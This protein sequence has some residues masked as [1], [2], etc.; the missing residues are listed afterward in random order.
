MN[1]SETVI[2]DTANIPL[3]SMAADKDISRNDAMNRV[4][5]VTWVGMGVNILLTAVKMGAGLAGGSQALVADAVHS[6]SDCSTDIA[7]LVGVRYWSNPPDHTHPHGHW[8]I[9]TLITTF[10][11]VFLA[12]AAV[13][14]GWKG[15]TSFGKPITAQLGYIPLLAALLSV[16][17]KEILYRWTLAEGR[18][19]HS[20]AV[21]A[22][23]WH[24]R[25]DAISSIPVAIAIAVCMA[26]PA[27]GF[28]DP[29]GA[30]AVCIFLLKASWSILF[31]AL[32][33]LS[34]K[35][36]D[37]ESMV[38]IYRIAMKVNG[39]R[40]VHALRTRTMASRVVADLHLMV[41]PDLSVQEGHAIAGKVKATILDHEMG[42]VDLLIHLEPWDGRTQGD[43]IEG[44]PR[45][46]FS[47][48]TDN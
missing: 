34:D 43:G 33:E 42:V 39:V 9:E 17:C 48:Q 45:E 5:H 12:I 23:A 16:V 37:T 22:N 35:A 32:S 8:R 21:I 15:L 44:D 36:I 29:L 2:T 46:T 30:L 13:A 41:D 38:E 6:L 4:L 28:L 27:F 31:P 7:V 18:K 25:S 19:V 24:H 40:H 11:G 26:N 14:I 20:Q 10:I 3:T 47:I 1:K